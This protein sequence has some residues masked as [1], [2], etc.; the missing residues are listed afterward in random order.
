M[1]KKIPPQEPRHHPRAGRPVRSSIRLLR[2]ARGWRQI[3]LA[4]AAACKQ[5][6]VSELELGTSE[7]TPELRARI[8]GALEASVEELFPSFVKQAAVEAGAPRGRRG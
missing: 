7:G 4:R 2:L 3:D 8:A 5:D 1:S 6:V